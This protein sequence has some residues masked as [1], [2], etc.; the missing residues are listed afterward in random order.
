MDLTAFWSHWI[1][2][3]VTAIVGF[4]FA[5]LVL[6]QYFERRKPHQIAWLIGLLFY[7]VAAV[8]EA[9]SE[10]VWSWNPYVYRVYIVLAAS[11]VGF[12]GL[13]TLYLLSKRRIWGHLYAA[14][15]VLAM[16]VFIYGTMTTELATEFL[17]PGITVGGKALGASFSFPRVM[18][19]FFNIPGTL[20]LLGGA[21]YSV[22]LFSR[23]K[24]YAYRMW[25]NVIIAAGTMVI[26]T[27]GSMAR[28]GRAV[29]LYPAEMVGS[30]L[31]LWGFLKAST[32]DRGAATIRQSRVRKAAASDSTRLPTDP[33][34]VESIDEKADTG[35]KALETLGEERAPEKIT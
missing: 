10:Y 12:L 21:I 29:G 15:N 17:K 6:R 32:L 1:W 18:S 16:A 11:L 4:F 22:I 20:L 19:F 23:K 3:L 2:P 26:A 34:S 8:M 33:K 28:T 35:S 31:L 27:V 7:S 5:Y 25:A 24:E 30:A 14:F 9:Y 13:G